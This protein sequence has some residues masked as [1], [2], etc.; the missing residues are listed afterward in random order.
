VRFSR[1]V[2]R[3]AGLS[4][5]DAGLVAEQLAWRDLR[6]EVPIGLAALPSCVEALRSGATDAKAVPHLAR[7]AGALA[8]VDG[9][10]VWGQ[11]TAVYAMHEA[12]TRAR[13]HG[14]GVAVVRDSRTANVMGYYPTLAIDAGMVG[15]AITNSEPYQ[16]PWGGTTKVLGNQAYALGA[17]AARHHPLLFDGAATQLSMG[18]IRSLA[19]RGLPLPEGGA[20]D[21]QGRPTLDPVAA[22]T[23]A[24]LPSG[25][26][27]GYALSVFWEILTGALADDQPA[28]GRDGVERTS[29]FLLAI[30]PRAT[31]GTERFLQSV[32]ELIDRIHASPPAAGVARVWAPGERGYVT[33]EERRAKGVPFTAVR[34][35]ELQGLGKS[36]GVAW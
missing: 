28:A 32:D 10:G 5:D 19:R 29:L 11:L 4:T 2:L 30:D 1:E 20:L 23:G 6:E 31:V 15:L 36:L 26:Y 16:P 12:V 13:A 8:V 22:L 27:K 34:I 24:L 18:R 35:A 7:D 25:G 21:A 3:A 33:A 9:A 14:V 17:P